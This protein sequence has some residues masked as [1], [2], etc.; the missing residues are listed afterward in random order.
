MA[1]VHINNINVLNNPAPILSPLQF[2]ITF[3]CFK[4][5]P[6]TFDWKIIY[7]GSPTD[8]H[9]D[10]VIDEFDMSDIQPGCMTFNTDSNPPDFSKIP[11]DEV[12]GT[13]AILISVLYEGQ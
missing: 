7:L 5:L 4:K 1:Q 13:T 2:E 8:S 12:V 10:Q 9:Y 6:G 11:N 3:E